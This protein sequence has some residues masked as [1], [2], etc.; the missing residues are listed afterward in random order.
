MSE[1][2]DVHWSISFR[3]VELAQAETGSANLERTLHSLGMDVRKGWMDDGRWRK[4]IVT[5]GTIAEVEETAE[6]F[7][8]RSLSGERVIGPRYIGQARSDGR[9]RSIISNELNLAT[10][11]GHSAGAAS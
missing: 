8:H 4:E 1:R 7:F 3:D 2:N 5:K 11:F 6:G 10:E 9:W